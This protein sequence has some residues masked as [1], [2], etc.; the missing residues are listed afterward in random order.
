MLGALPDIADELT[1]HSTTLPRTIPDDSGTR[2][3][4]VDDVSVSVSGPVS[5]PVSV[6][7]SENGGR[8]TTATRTPDPKWP[9]FPMLARQELF[10]YWQ[11]KIGTTNL[12]TLTNAIGP[13]WRPPG[14]LDA[15]RVAVRDYCGLVTKGR[16]A[17]FATPKDL[18]KKLGALIGNAT[19]NR[20]DAIARTDGAEIILHGQRPR[21]G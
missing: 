18:A 4:L 3:L 5:V 9:D 21:V 1:P 2:P 17:P 20:G 6:S 12:T 11:A 16:S 15:V 13:Y 10:G 8:K 19:L 7:V 14:D